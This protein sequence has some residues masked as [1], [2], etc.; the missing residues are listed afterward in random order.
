MIKRLI[1]FLIKIY[2]FSLSAVMGRQCR[3]HPTCSAYTVEALE[4][5][6]LFKGSILAIKR[7]T[8]CHPWGR[9]GVDPVP[10]RFEPSEAF[11]GFKK[12]SKKATNTKDQKIK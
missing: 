2:Q 12:P 11:H 1:I 3:F 9:G 8:S 10:E 5:H 7:I 4:R 6:G